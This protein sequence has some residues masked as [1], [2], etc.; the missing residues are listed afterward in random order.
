[1][2]KITDCLGEY[3][4]F[5]T[6]EKG[7][8]DQSITSYMMCLNQFYHYISKAEH[9]EM[10]EEVDHDMIA[11][12]IDKL[13]E[14]QLADS[15]VAHTISTLRNFFRF[16]E[17][18]GYI[19]ENPMRFIS[20]P[21]QEKKLP[22]VMSEEEVEKFLDCIE[23]SD[24][25]TCRDRCMFELMYATGLRV[26]ELL[27]LTLNDVYLNAKAIRCVGKGDKERMIPLSQYICDLLTIYINDYRIHFKNASSSPY[28]FLNMQGK[29]MTRQ[30][31]TKLTQFYANKANINKH[32][33]PHT[34]R[35][36]FATHLLDHGTDLRS[37][38]ELLGH[39]NISTT[40]IYTHITNQRIQEEYYKYHPRAK[41]GK[42]N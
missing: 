12:Y 6:I 23:I 7:L 25:K 9:K 14:E 20:S 17:R 18:E 15:T 19:K 1:M 29:P 36:S 8:A 34:L 16:I 13:K 21:K 2:E 42:E 32:I 35:H 5:L 37:I 41:K 10:I 11:R 31:F 40:T 4:Q 33:S 28:L 30:G 27:S 39:S 26:S 3:E 24:N 38:Q 22:T